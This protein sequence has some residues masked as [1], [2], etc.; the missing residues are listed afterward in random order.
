M[1][2]FI[3]SLL[4]AAALPLA[5]QADD[6]W[7]ERPVQVVI[8]GS[9]GGDTDFNAREMAKFFEQ[10]T[11]TPMAVTNMPGGGGT[12]AT[13]EVRQARPDGSTVLFAH[14]G[15]YIVTEV[16]GLQDFSWDTFEVCCVAAVD[17]GAV[18]V[19]S[20]KFKSLDQLVAQLKEDP[21]S[22]TYGTEFGG[23][24]HLQGLIFSDLAG[25]EMKMVDT[26]TASEK[27]AALL[28]GRID[29]AAITYGVAADYAKSGLLTILAQPNAE[30]SPLI[31]DVPTFAEQGVDF[32]LDK[33]YM[34][35]FPPGTDPAIVA[36]MDEI[37]KQITENPDYAEDLRKGYNQPVSYL[38]HDATQEMMTGLRGK[39]MAYLDDLRAAR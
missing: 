12:I 2:T 11:G 32:V 15:Q 25:V 39:L 36:R 13:N 4:A 8:P 1:K 22:V 24:S 20:P 5:A 7:P 27:L 38:G 30:R 21:G 33:P 17:K 26:G 35:G 23:Y 31:P 9:A 34:F 19:A 16:S 3:L 18:F 6:A 37:V 29:L 10:I 28:G 14:V